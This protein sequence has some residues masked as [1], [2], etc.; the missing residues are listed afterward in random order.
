MNRQPLDAG[1]PAIPCREVTRTTR[2]SGQGARS[3]RGLLLYGRRKPATRASRARY[4]ASLSALCKTFGPLGKATR[5]RQ[6]IDQSGAPVRFPSRLC[7]GALRA[8]TGPYRAL[9]GASMPLGDAPFSWAT[10]HRLTP[11]VGPR[12]RWWRPL[13]SMS[14]GHQVQVNVR[15]PLAVTAFSVATFPPACAARPARLRARNLSRLK[16]LHKPPQQSSLQFSVER[17]DVEVGCAC[18]KGPL[19]SERCPA[20]P[21]GERITKTH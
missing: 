9:L 7:A 14:L 1:T 16:G 3:R 18:D 15:R 5:P 11:P 8:I 19:I 10:G 2:A 17:C 21:H 13:I 6:A 20:P 4:M 12:L